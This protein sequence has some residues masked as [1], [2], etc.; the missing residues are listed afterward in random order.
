[1][2]SALSGAGQLCSLCGDAPPSGLLALRTREFLDARGVGAGPAGRSGGRDRAVCVSGDSP[3]IQAPQLRASG[4]LGSCPGPSGFDGTEPLYVQG[5]GSGGF[6]SCF[7][8]SQAGPPL[9]SK[10]GGQTAASAEEALPKVKAKAAKAKR[11]TVQ[12]LASQQIAMMDLMT[13][14]VNRLAS[15]EQQ[16]L[17]QAPRP[18]APFQHVPKHLAATLGPPPQ[19][20]AQHPATE[21][22]VDL[23]ATLAR[24]I[25]DAELPG[26]LWPQL[27]STSR[28]PFWFW[29]AR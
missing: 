4:S 10:C 24:G 16:A 20:R 11:P 8:C 23:D 9:D 2:A 3:S 19:V 27:W 21:Q 1:M 18:E 5:W 12:Q 28:R 15:Q 29:S 6:P 22:Q 13:S 17:A 7:G 26:A 25:G 14:V